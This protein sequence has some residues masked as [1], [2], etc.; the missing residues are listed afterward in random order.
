[1]ASLA[2]QFSD[3]QIDEFKEKEVHSCILC[4]IF[5]NQ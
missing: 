1:M 2:D 3:Q 4:V 5:V